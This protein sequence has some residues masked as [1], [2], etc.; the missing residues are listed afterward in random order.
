MGYLI[1]SKDN[2]PYCVKA[3]KLLR[4][5]DIPFDLVNVPRDLTKDEFRSMFS[6]MGSDLTVPRI[7]VDNDM[8]GGYTELVKYISERGRR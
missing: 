5:H 3:K 7:F 8:I 6:G 4:L 1:V 2:C